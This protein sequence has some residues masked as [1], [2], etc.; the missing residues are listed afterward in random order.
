MQ[1]SET[2]IANFEKQGHLFFLGLLGADDVLA[3]QDAMPEILKRSGPEL[4]CESGDPT[5]ARL[6]SGRTSSPN[7]FARF[8]CVH[9]F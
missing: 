8:R 5:A 1:L 9:A 3:M 7:R 6:V 4:V 2:Q